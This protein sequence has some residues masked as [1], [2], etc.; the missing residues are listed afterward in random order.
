MR[1]KSLIATAGL[2][3]ALAAP[4]AADSG[5]FI[6]GVTDFPAAHA[7]KA[8]YVPGVT[9]FPRATGY[10]VLTPAAPVA[11]VTGTDDGIEWV[12]AGI[13]AAIGATAGLGLL[14][15]ALVVRRRITVA[16]S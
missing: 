10:R 15:S 3:L 8:P 7:V 1:S 12:D 2:A 14:G 9:D 4:A 11:T 13:G 16:H 6:Q 5:K